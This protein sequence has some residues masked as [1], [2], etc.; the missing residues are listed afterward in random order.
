MDFYEKIS[1]SW[2]RQKIKSGVTF[3]LASS[4]RGGL[5]TKKIKLIS[6]WVSEWQGHLLRGPGQLKREEGGNQGG[7]GGRL[8]LN[9]FLW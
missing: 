8:E 1:Q 7:K 6:Y 4:F 5:K 2:A 9:S 3:L